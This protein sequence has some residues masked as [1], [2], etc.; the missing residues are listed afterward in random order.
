MLTTSV[1][2]L[3]GNNIKLTVTV[4]A[5]EV[6]AAI[7]SA[8]ESVGKKVRIPGFRKGHAP[9]P[10]V[11]NYLGKEYVLSE[12]TEV[13][14]DT[15]YPRAVDAESIRPIDSPDIGELDLVVPGEP[16][17][18]VAE[19]ETRPELTLSHTDDIAVTVPPKHVTEAQIDEQIEFARDKFA[20]LEPVEDRALEA[21]DFALISFVG[22]VDGEPYE[23]NQVD[24]YLYE[25]GK[26]AM[27][28]EFDEGLIGMQP[29][30]EKRIE[31][32]IPD[33]SSKEEYVG[34]T[35]GF[36]VTVH[37]IKKKVLPEV[38]DE[39]ATSV[40]GYD[41]VEM[42]RED[43]RIRMGATQEL[44]HERAKEAALKKVLAERLV[45]EVPESMI[46]TK[47]SQLLRDFQNQLEQSGM[48]VESYSASIGIPVEVIEADIN[49]QGEQVVR[50]ELALE[51]LFR[52]EG[53]EITDE[54]VRNDIATMITGSQTVE[55]MLA[56]WTENGL[57]PVVREQIAQQRAVQWL[58]EHGTV[59]ESDGTE[60]AE[61]AAEDADNATTEE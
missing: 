39:F 60:A 11:D 21:N 8:Y 10:V 38:D 12:A 57:I 32:T 29:G 7:K 30:E 19:V 56:R 14:V 20:S 43:L 2:P 24:K 48:T 61:T 35:A 37:E 44:Q 23:G 15:T 42:M 1:E 4:P 49:E 22:D 13:L 59:T 53:M 33:T 51:A 27:P 47:T 26:G 45:G 55:D 34:K 41:N 28:V 36:D 6:D 5:E 25:L 17:T 40:G 58:L 54:D 52:Q 46:R 16:F 18:Y 3:E 50:E 9:R 31:F